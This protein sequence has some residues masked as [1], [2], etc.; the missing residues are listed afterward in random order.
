MKRLLSFLLCIFLLCSVS[1]VCAEGIPALHLMNYQQQDNSLDLLLYAKDNSYF[2]ADS[3]TVKIDNEEVPTTSL[4]ALSSS[5]YGTSWIVLVEPAAYASIENMVVSLVESL[6]TRLGDHDRLAVYDLSSGEITS[7][8]KDAPTVREFAKSAVKVRE[9]AHVRL[10][11]G[12]HYALSGFANDPA[13][14]LHKCI[15]IVS[16]GVDSNSTYTL[17]ELRSEMEKSDVSVYTVGITRSVRTYA[18][19]YKELSGLSRVTPSGLTM[20]Y[21]NFPADAGTDAAKQIMEN[22]KNCFVLSADLTDVPA[23]DNA[24]VTVSLD[25]QYASLEHVKIESSVQADE[26]CEHEWGDNATCQ[27]ARTCVK[28]GIED[29]DG[30]PVAHE[31]DGSGH[32]KWCQEPLSLSFRAVDWVKQNVI[33]AAMGGVLFLLLIVLLIVLAKRRKTTEADE[34]SFIEDTPGETTFVRSKVTVELTKKTTGERFVGDIM[35]STLKA[36]RAAPLRIVGDGAI[37]QEHMEFIWQN[38]ILYVQDTNS[39]NGTMVNGRAITGAVP[40]Y[41]NDLIHAGESDFFV[42]WH[43]NS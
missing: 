4:T 10:F 26:I 2:S 30:K 32:C 43:S 17:Y 20:A 27:S 11:D 33:L 16:G 38:G 34:E 22:E 28:C 12:I 7:F 39:K 21:D 6:V 8:V 35:D 25:S 15:L 18:E 37:S 19:A 23:T 13:H 5:D 14:N 9:N 29:P 42:T 3:F 36:G 24:T 31:D 1:G 41:Q 40:L